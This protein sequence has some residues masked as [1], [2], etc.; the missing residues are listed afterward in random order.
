[1]LWKSTYM[2]REIAINN[3]SKKAYNP[4]FG[5]ESNHTSQN[6]KDEEAQNVIT[7]GAYFPFVGA[8][9]RAKN[10]NLVIDTS[11]PSKSIDSNP[12]DISI[13]ELYKTVSEEIQTKNLPNITQEFLLFADGKELN[14]TFLKP[15]S[16]EEEPIY[17][18]LDNFP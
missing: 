1:M 12:S 2:D 5:L 7:F 9:N 14:S 13:E 18:V 6:I 4:N 16:V 8:G 10:W 3:F 11:K 17:A 15:Y